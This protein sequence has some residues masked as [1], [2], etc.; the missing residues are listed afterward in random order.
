[1][2]EK[3]IPTEPENPSLGMDTLN[4]AKVLAKNV[5]QL[6]E[7]SFPGPTGLP[8]YGM[9]EKLADTQA[10]GYS[11]N[12]SFIRPHG[13]HLAAGGKDFIITIS[14]TD[15]ASYKAEYF[16][17]VWNVTDGT[18]TRLEYGLFSEDLVFFGGI[19]LFNALY[20]VFDY[21]MTTNHTSAYRTKNLIIEY[22]GS[23]W[24]VRSMGID[25]IPSLET[26][27]TGDSELSNFKIPLQYHTSLVFDNKMWVIGG[28]KNTSPAELSRDVYSSKDGVFWTKTGELP[29]N[30]AFHTSVVFQDKMWAIC[31]DNGGLQ[32][33]VYYSSDGATWATSVNDFPILL[34][35]HSSVVFK[36]PADSV[37]KIW[38]IG[39]VTSEGQPSLKVYC[40]PDGLNWTEKGTNVLPGF[41]SARHTVL[42]FAGLMWIIG[43]YPNI[44]K[45]YSSPDGIVW[46]EKGSDTLPA[47]TYAHSSV[48]FSGQMWMICG[49]DSIASVRKVYSSYNGIAWTEQG[50]N[51]MPVALA[52]HSSVVYNNKIW[53]ICGYTTLAVKTIYSSING[54]TWIQELGGILKNYYSSV[55][56]TFIKRTTFIGLDTSIFE[57]PI[58]ESME[59]LSQRQIVKMLCSTDTGTLLIPMPQNY[60]SAVAQGATHMRIW[61]T[62]G[63][64]SG[65]VAAGLSHHFL[66]DISLTAVGFSVYTIY[67]DITT[68]A[69]L[70]GEENFLDTTGYDIPPQGRFIAYI[71]SRLVIGGNPLNPGYW[72]CSELPLNTAVPQKF[73]SMFK[74][75]ELY[76]TCDP[77]DNQKDSGCAVLS[78]NLYLFKE[79]KVFVLDN[80]DF[81][82]IPRKISSTI[83]CACPQ[84]I[85]EADIPQLGGQ[86][87]LFQSESGPAY[88]TSSGQ[89][90]LL[91]RFSIAELWPRK[92][93][94]L[95]LSTGLPTD[96]YTRNKVTAAFWDNTWRIFFGDSRDTE[97][98][99]AVNKVFGFRF[100]DDS[101][102]IG[103]FQDTFPQYVPVSTAY[104]I[105]E[106]RML[107]PVDN[108][109][110][111]AFSHK[112]NSAGNKIYRLVR[113]CDPS[114]FQDTFLTEGALAYSMKYRTRYWYAGTLRCA[115]ADLKKILL[116]LYF[117]DTAGLTVNIYADG[118]RLVA[119]CTYSQ[120]RQSG[121]AADNTFRHF[122]LITIKGDGIPGSFFDMLISKVVPSTGAI[123]FFGVEALIDNIQ[124]MPKEEFMSASSAL[125]GSTTY[126]V[127]ADASPEVPA[128][129]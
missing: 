34:E 75:K 101:E 16:I 17:E 3:I 50:T 18:R 121:M 109:R 55:A 104:T 119:P 120:V 23:A 41:I 36:D 100:G 113:Y 86:V 70:T 74:P 45:V 12:S 122:V 117:Q 91:T 78:G 60:A 110:A 66:V 94:V 71:G 124:E 58:N 125:T 10:L 61:R 19:K 2:A 15:H 46:T 84:T 30:L 4:S 42:S 22:V 48:V 6:V 57:E 68:D 106:P 116:Y 77:Y 99:I 33:K 11:S 80:G 90:E 63:D 14:R 76:I 85:C 105:Y 21:A 7:N 115:T 37:L 31:G 24:A 111:Y 9:N 29:D 5:W 32:K 38:V 59:D 123:E 114:K 127:Q 87:I 39:G 53:V 98:N 1:M 95:M 82:N 49:E 43:G 65:T 102:S 92:V 89:I 118:T 25:A 56:T 108:I 126:V 40:S 28:F 44:K 51:A 96:W 73:A 81:N 103:A 67:H 93:G 112:T 83:G 129:P 54:A 27:Q 107:V 20:L 8:R 26:I 47:V 35:W 128:F 64:S 79:R 72:F 88:I 52:G 13:W 69:A 62:L 97:D